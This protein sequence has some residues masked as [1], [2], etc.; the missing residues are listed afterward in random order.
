MGKLSLNPNMLLPGL[1]P[2]GLAAAAA[3]VASGRSPAGILQPPTPNMTGPIRRRVSDKASL[4][5]SGGE[6]LTFPSYSPS[7]PHFQQ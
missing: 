5:L 6:H 7:S 3:A 2:S 4:P 1:S